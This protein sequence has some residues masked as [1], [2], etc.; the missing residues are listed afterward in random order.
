MLLV[1]Q[2]GQL[3]PESY[4]YNFIVN[5]IAHRHNGELYNIKWPNQINKCNHKEW[6]SI[7]SERYNSEGILTHHHEVVEL[8]LNNMDYIEKYG[9]PDVDGISWKI[10]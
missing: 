4:L 9:T 7:E 1:H 6:V 2:I 8:N 10:I 3:V 5:E